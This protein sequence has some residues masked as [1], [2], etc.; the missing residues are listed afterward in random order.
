MMM[1]VETL[2]R[3]ES[4]VRALLDRWVEATLALDM[5]RILACYDPDIRAFDAIGPL[6]FD[7]LG[8]YARHWKSC[9]E[10]MTGE[11]VFEPDQLRIELDGDLAV[12]HFLVRCGCAGEDGAM[13]TN[14]MRGT[15][16]M[17]RHAGDW[18]IVHE[19]YSHP[20]DV[21]TMK[22]AMDLKP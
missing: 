3:A 11:M 20:F 15:V 9:L 4:E 1:M 19:H 10:M 12:T 21:E 22:V 16:C 8:V 14:W 13:Q 17:R 5:D 7:G 2:S 6:Q 18:R